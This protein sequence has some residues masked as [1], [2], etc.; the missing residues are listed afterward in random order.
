MLFEGR[1]DLAPVL[2][3]DRLDDVRRLVVVDLDDELAEVGLHAFDAMLL[4]ETPSPVSSETIVLDFTIFVAPWR[5]MMV[6][7]AALAAW[8]VAAQWTVTP[9]AWSLASTCGR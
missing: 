7:T 6:S 2:V 4:E 3:D 9:F 5:R 1:G 8:A